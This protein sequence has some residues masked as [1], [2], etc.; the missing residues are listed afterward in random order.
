MIVDMNEYISIVPQGFQRAEAIRLMSIHENQPSDLRD[1]EVFQSRDADIMHGEETSD[2]LLR[3]G[4]QDQQ[5]AGIELAACDHGGKSVKVSVEMSGDDIHIDHA[6]DTTVCRPI[7]VSLVERR[8]S[9][10]IVMFYFQSVREL[11][12][13]TWHSAARKKNAYS[14]AVGRKSV[15]TLTNIKKAKCSNIFWSWHG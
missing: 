14:C 13:C 11:T 8:K 10:Y 15:L 7:K 12:D 5:S 3:A 9:P 6:Q 2:R 4:G 1:V